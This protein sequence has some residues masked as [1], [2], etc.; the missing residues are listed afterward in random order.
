MPPEGD[1]RTLS[2]A[3]LRELLL[4]RIGDTRDGDDQRPS[5]EPSPE[6]QADPVAAK[7]AHPRPLPLY[8]GALPLLLGAAVIAGGVAVVV[9]AQRT[10]TPVSSPAAATGQL[11]IVSDVP[12]AQVSIDGQKR[13]VTPLEVALDPGPHAVQFTSGGW[14]ETMAVSIAPAS[15]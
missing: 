14:R 8:L 15:A 10:V 4:P 11:S 7:A 1:V 12:G 6:P 13:G 5:S 9:V 3:E 2:I